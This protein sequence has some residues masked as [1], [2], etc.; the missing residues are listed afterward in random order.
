[1]CN[2]IIYLGDLGEGN[3][4]SNNTITRTIIKKNPI[5]KHYIIETNKCLFIFYFIIGIITNNFKF[6]STLFD[7][8]FSI[9]FIKIIKKIIGYNKARC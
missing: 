2:F 1:M 4:S 5:Y 7:L 8:M 6:R 3:R 9:F